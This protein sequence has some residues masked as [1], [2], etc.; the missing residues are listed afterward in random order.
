MYIK[1]IT[2]LIILFLIYIYFYFFKNKT[3]IV[4][5]KQEDGSIII[6]KKNNDF[7]IDLEDLKYYKSKENFISKI[8]PKQI[9]ITHHYDNYQNTQIQQQ[10]IIIPQNILHEIDNNSQNVHDTFIQEN[11]KKSH[12]ELNVIPSYIENPETEDQV[13]ETIKEEFPDTKDIINHIKN[14]NSFIS[15]VSKTEKQVIHDIWKVCLKDQNIKNN[16]ITQLLDCRDVSGSGIVCGTGVVTRLTCSL[17][18]NDPESMP[19]DKG[20]IKTEVLNKF[21]VLANKS[22]N[23]DLF[24]NEI[25]FDKYKAKEII[26]GDYS[27]NMKPKISKIIDEFIEFI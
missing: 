10:E 12:N 8:I 16:F 9:E 20:I 7:V 5:K 6:N 21:S 11:I 14:R 2:S 13:L 26:L 24:K 27:D 23:I 25:P 17:Y 4:L 1:I 3:Q 18:V 15:N 19:K 22:E